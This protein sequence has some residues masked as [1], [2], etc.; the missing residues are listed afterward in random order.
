MCE[1]LSLKLYDCV[2]CLEATMHDCTLELIFFTV[3][4]HYQD[5]YICSLNF[6]NFFYFFIKKIKN[7]QKIHNSFIYKQ[8]SYL[9]VQILFILV[10]CDVINKQYIDLCI[11][12]FFLIFNKKI[13]GTCVI[14]IDFLNVVFNFSIY[15]L[16]I[17]DWN[18]FN[19]LVFYKIFLEIYS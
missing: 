4:Q 1:H 10:L 14:F 2:H 16:M 19:N 13:L 18:N 5:E 6:L 9:E 3:L 17:I 11:L 12:R 7:F 8:W 15:G